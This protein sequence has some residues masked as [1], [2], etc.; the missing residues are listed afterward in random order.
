M[1][2]AIDAMGGDKA[3][4]PIVEGV[5]QAASLVQEGTEIILVGQESV[6]RRE[7]KSRFMPRELPISVVHAS[8]V[9][10]MD[11]AP[12]I[13]MRKKRD[14]SI[15]V[16]VDLLKRGQADA[17]VSAGNTGAVMAAAL[18]ELGRLKGVSRPAIASLFPTERD[19]VVVLD[20]GANASCKAVHLYQFG[21]MGATYA[22]HILRRRRPK[23]GL[24]SIGEESSKGNEAT[25]KAHQ[26]LSHSP[27]NFV[28]NIEGRD[29]LRGNVDVAVCDGF[30]GNVMLKFT[31]SIDGLLTAQLRRYV[32]SRLR[33][34]LGAHL[35]MPA[36]LAFRRDLDY[37]EYGGVPLLGLNGVCII[38]HGGSSAKAIRKA[39]AVAQQ[40]VKADVNSGILRQLQEN[41]GMKK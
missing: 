30:V 16:A 8:Q 38:C 19:A 1:K 26:M 2:I 12:A 4:H 9:V 14:S 34:R 35:L 13:A 31:E 7:L 15:M 6:I 18:V 33:Y 40:M 36:L 41:G 17:F 32:M 28:G 10:G 25:V 23:V 24:L 39:I 20:V 5:V 22:S 21:V 3:P 37:A 29:I 11:E 27:L